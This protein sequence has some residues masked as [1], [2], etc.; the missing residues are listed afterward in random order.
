MKEVTISVPTGTFPADVGDRVRVSLTKLNG[1]EFLDVFVM[2]L[3]TGC[4]V[5]DKVV[6]RYDETLLPFGASVVTACMITGFQ[7]QCSCCSAKPC[8]EIFSPGENVVEGTRHVLILPGDYRLDELKFYSPE[9]A[10]VP[11]KLQVLVDGV[12]LF[13]HTLTMD[14]ELLAVNRPAF[15]A[16]FDSGLIPAGATIEVVVVDAPQN[17]YYEAPWQGLSL[18]LLGIWYPHARTAAGSLRRARGV[19]PPP[20]V[21][22]IYGYPANVVVDGEGNYVVDGEGNFVVES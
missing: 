3:T 16:E 9:V 1:L 14:E 22:P 5:A 7:K 13:P 12:E 21:P 17:V 2:S 10:E 4:G 20:S 11:L 8:Y 6:L 18:C 19:R 15:A